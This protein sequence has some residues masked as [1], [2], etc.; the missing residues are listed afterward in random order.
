M[1]GC[2]SVFL[3]LVLWAAL[4]A[5][6]QP[7][8]LNP[9]QA[10][11]ETG[12]GAMNNGRYAEAIPAFEDALKLAAAFPLD[13]ARVTDTY[14]TL[15]RC[16]SFSGNATMADGFVSKLVAKYLK[17]Y[18]L[19]DARMVK[20]YLTLGDH[21]R[22]TSGL[23]A[24]LQQWQNALSV[25][26]KAYGEQDPRLADIYVKI[27]E[28]YRGNGRQADA[29]AA[30][31]QAVALFGEGGETAALIPVLTTLAGIYNGM[32]KQTEAT[33]AYAR[34]VAVHEKLYGA[35]DQRTV[36]A[37]TTF[38]YSLRNGGKPLEI[39]PVLERLTAQL[40]RI[41]ID[42]AQTQ[43]R[44]LATLYVQLG[45]VAKADALLVKNL[46]DTLGRGA[47]ANP[48]ILAATRTLIDFYLEQERWADAETRGQQLV[49]AI[50][51]AQTDEKTKSFD[52][53]RLAI[54][55]RARGKDADLA[56]LTQKIA[57][58]LTE[59]EKSN[60]KGSSPY[61]APMYQA[62]GDWVTVEQLH[63]YNVNSRKS[64]PFRDNPITADLYLKLG[65][66]E[67]V[68]KKPAD[69]EKAF[70]TALDIMEKVTAPEHPAVILPLIRTAESLLAQ[71]KAA[72]ALALCAR[73]LAIADKEIPDSRL[74]ARLLRVQAAA[75]RKA[76]NA[77]DADKAIARATGIEGGQ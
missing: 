55:L 11:M 17:T 13:D 50:E 39:L 10:A 60:P 53:A 34:L 73:A 42:G 30:M 1:T 69:A 15:A 27:A 56:P 74:T 72:D 43:V 71:D 45:Q 37:L 8:V 62:V 33:A 66:S 22:M 35:D 7:E 40:R 32:Q 49:E 14:L 46:D 58:T 29:I 5:W 21:Y 54:A 70:R 38:Y 9:W 67:L 57:A 61:L 28:A 52:R 31:Q 24:A 51:N 18:G 19:Q 23:D 4:A 26:R 76:G 6:A 47:D 20:L 59:L 64:P 12:R 48:A 63:A 44:E 16:Y 2:R 3:M 25:A 41:S 75:L 68:L 77:V 36:G 65:N